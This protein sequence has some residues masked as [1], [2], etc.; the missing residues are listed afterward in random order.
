MTTK[1][2]KKRLG[3]LGGGHLASMLAESALRAGMQPVVLGQSRNEPAARDDVLWVQGGLGDP[4]ALAELFRHSDMVTTETEFVD[5]NVLQAVQRRFPE[6]HV[7][8]GIESLRAGQDKLAQKELFKN[9]NLPS[10]DCKRLP[11]GA[12]EQQMESLSQRFPSGFVLKFAKFS[13]D[14]RG[15]FTV[16]PGQQVNLSDVGHFCDA[17][18]RAGTSVFT[19]PLVDVASELAVVAART[20]DGRMQCFPLVETHQE[21]G[22]CRE[23]V[24][25]AAHLGFPAWIASQTNESVCQLA[26]A[27]SLEGVLVVKFFVTADGKLL[28]NKFS[29][30][31]HNLGLYRTDG[32][33]VSQFDLHIEAILGRALTV[34]HG[35]GFTLVRRI[36][37]PE[38]F[39]TERPCPAPDRRL[40]DGLRL[41]WYDKPNV[42]AGRAMGHLSGSARSSRALRQLQASMRAYETQ[43]WSAVAGVKRAS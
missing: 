40:P 35:L 27:L 28:L 11:T 36:L 33:D 34:P 23:I 1:Q 17:A 12:L 26:E 7:A 37:G 4:A 14:G 39:D 42:V 16:A 21:A 43:H 6:V 24:G 32:S 25:P 38:I 15:N 18:S 22:M 29:P 2:R 9:L 8:P 41:N 3:I 19:E 5:T 13:F 30:R 31:V 20:A 10:V